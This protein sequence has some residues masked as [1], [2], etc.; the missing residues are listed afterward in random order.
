LPN[1]L[2]ALIF[3]YLKKREI[4]SVFLSCKRFQRII[5]EWPKDYI[6]TFIANNP[7]EN[8][9][10]LAFVKKFAPRIE[11]YALDICR[12]TT[13]PSGDYLQNL[14]TLT[15][16]GYQFSLGED[17][18]NNLSHLI[19]KGQFGGFQ[20][21]K[22][23]NISNLMTIRFHCFP[24]IK[25]FK[26]IKHPPL[27]FEHTEI[28]K[29]SCSFTCPLVVTLIQGKDVTCQLGECSYEGPLD[30]NVP[31]GE[32]QLKHKGEIVFRGTFMWGRIASGEGSIVLKDRTISNFWTDTATIHYH[33]GAFF[34]GNFN[35]K[36]ILKDSLGR[37]FT[38]V[39]KNGLPSTGSGHIIL[40]D[41]NWYE[42]EI[43]EDQFQGFGRCFIDGTLY[44]GF[45]KNHTPVG[46]FLVTEHGKPPFKTDHANIPL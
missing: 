3:T 22:L 8:N 32:G 4:G 15:I 6:R 14:D 31:H 36:G 17:L 21:R 16:T 11:K 19:V 44:E 33:D 27:K 41:D 30:N 26:L 37:T 12:L 42:G 2:F 38:G 46:S 20:F 1:D 18:P 28:Y 39:F 35:G 9:K 7:P 10:D 34:T 13:F 45:F 43:V 29:L 40:E 23:M 25:M 24:N 5:D